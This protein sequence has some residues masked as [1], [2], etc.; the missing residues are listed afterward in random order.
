MFMLARKP[1]PTAARAAAPKAAPQRADRPP[2]VNPLWMRLAM[3]TSPQVQRKPAVS[4][5]GDPSEREADDVAD[6]VMRMADPAP[7]GPAARAI[8][9]ECAGCKGGDE[10][11]G[12][13]TS[14]PPA[15]AGQGTPLSREER[16]FFEPRF[17]RDFS[18]VRL[19][20]GPEAAEASRRLSA[21]AFTH[22]TDIYFGRGFHQPGH[23]DGRRLL[24]HELTHVIQQTGPGRPQAGM[25]QRSPLLMA[26][27]LISFLMKLE[28]AQADVDA[29]ASLN[30]QLDALASRPPAAKGSRQP[31]EAEAAYKTAKAAAEAAVPAGFEFDWDGKKMEVKSFQIKSQLDVRSVSDMVTNYFGHGGK[32]ILGYLKQQMGTKVK[33]GCGK[34][35]DPEAG[36]ASST[37]YEQENP[38]V[39]ERFFKIRNQSKWKGEAFGSA[40]A[41]AFPGLS[42]HAGR[43]AFDLKFHITV[44]EE[45][46][47]ERKMSK[48]GKSSNNAKVRATGWWQ[49][50]N[51]AFS[52]N[53]FENLS[54][55]Y[56]HFD[57]KGSMSSPEKTLDVEPLRQELRYVAI[58]ANM[59]EYD[60]ADHL[61]NCRQAE[62]NDM[63]SWPSVI[64]LKKFIDSAA[65][66]E[67][68]VIDN[69][70]EAEGANED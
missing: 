16:E 37:W 46:G 21:R 28:K 67:L 43:G 30:D 9:R 22:G 40:G 53:N 10:K 23:P 8:Q 59:V 58:Y 63:E 52:D 31:A 50:V 66:L 24:A 18:N 26:P 29:D 3:S 60:L 44:K 38:G 49:E 48:W 5:P 62:I 65:N 1:L 69:S 55:E 68:N 64:L 56:W 70:G 61:A 34:G 36:A 12:R 13:A 20:D 42:R 15:S 7:V 41:A 6:R 4:S 14:G 32:Y 47:S 57:Y 35:G 17:H 2:P 25:V 39:T 19:H 11:P 33:K 45:G 27:G 54:S 51:D